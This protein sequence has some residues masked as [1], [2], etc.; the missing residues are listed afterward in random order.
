MDGMKPMTEPYETP[1]LSFGDCID[2]LIKARGERTWRE[3]S[4]REQCRYKSTATFYFCLGV[5]ACVSL[6]LLL[7][8]FIGA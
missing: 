7:R 5:L 1:S 2:V 3:L 6:E 8:G 4:H